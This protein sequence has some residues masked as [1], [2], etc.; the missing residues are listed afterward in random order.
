MYVCLQN[1]M[2]VSVQYRKTPHKHSLY[3]LKNEYIYING[4]LHENYS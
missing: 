1:L 3:P 4:Y 2:T